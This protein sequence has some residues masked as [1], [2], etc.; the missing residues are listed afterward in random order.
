VD[1][2]GDNVIDAF[3]FVSADSRKQSVQK[4]LECHREFYRVQAMSRGIFVLIAARVMG[5]LLSRP[6]AW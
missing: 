1:K 3:V 2:S 5:V 4:F 6:P